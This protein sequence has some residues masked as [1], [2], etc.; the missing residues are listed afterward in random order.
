MTTS[1]TNPRARTT[2]AA[3][4][5][6]FFLAGQL[7]IPLLGIEDDEALF[8]MP[9][10]QPKFWEYAVKVGKSQ[11]ALMLMSYLGTLKTLLYKPLLH[12]FGTGAW[13]VR[14][15]ALLAGAA[16]VWLFYLLLRRIAGERAAVVGCCLLAADTAYLLTTVFDWGPVALQHLLVTGA[17]LLA[18]KFYQDR[19][20]LALAAG[21]FLFGLAMWDKALAAWM[22]A[23][24]GV[25][26]LTVCW[27]ELRRSAGPRRFAIAI[28][29]FLLGALPLLIYNRGTHWATFRGNAKADTSGLAVK[30]EV[31]RQTVSGIGLLGLFTEEIRPAPAPRRPS[32]IFQ[33]ASATLAEQ[34][35]HPV[36]NLTL[37]GMAL[38]LLLT[39]L[40]RGR[41][42]RAVLFAWIAFGVAWVQMLFTYSAGGSVHHS[43]L[44]WPLPYV[45]LAVPLAAASRRIGRAGL[46]ALAAMVALLG[47]SSALV[48]NE[49]Y[50]RIVR[51][52]GSTAWSD[53]IWKL[54]DY[55]RG[56]TAVIYCVDWG[57]LD[58]LRLIGQG[59][60]L[61]RD[62]NEHTVKPQLTPEDREALRQAF[63]I[64]GALFVGH[65]KDAEIFPGDTARLLE[66]AS[67][68]GFRAELLATIADGV[69]RPVFEVYRFQ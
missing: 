33:R 27:R 68:S 23:G 28:L 47:V 19:S 54:N 17:M 56:S 65:T 15:P 44:L 58:N 60:L 46:P 16:S 41:D 31:L 51:Q 59:T 13:S 57:I 12:W 9:L 26:S 1:P 24:L 43:I 48:T 36:N 39:P 7:F 45:V 64:P 38:A 53:A 52:G 63:A 21:F 55:L 66:V 42:L 29:A 50:F 30:T 8:A 37:Y 6:L 4:C 62:G 40:A 2:A 69:G 3:A 11:L 61:V 5:F 20:D 34:T 25:A 18:V 67:Q 32:G 35:G 22:L 10:L 49:Y 14:E